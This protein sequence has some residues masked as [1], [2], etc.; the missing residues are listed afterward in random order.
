VAC[1]ASGQPCCGAGAA[2]TC[3]TGLTCQGAAGARTCRAAPDAGAPADAAAA[4]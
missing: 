4:G 3:N 1:G 2:A